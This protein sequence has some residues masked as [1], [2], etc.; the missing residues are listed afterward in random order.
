MEPID[1]FI[2]AS[3]TGTLIEA[4]LTQRIVHGQHDQAMAFASKVQIQQ[5]LPGSIIIEQG[6]ADNTLFFILMGEVSILINGNEIAL[7]QAGTHVGEMAL[8]EP[9]AKRSATV[10][11]RTTTVVAVI[12]ERDFTEI[13]NHY[14]NVWRQIA[15]ELGDRLRQRSRFIRAKNETP[16]MFIGSSRE[17]L[18]VVNTI[19]KGLAAAPFIVRPWTDGVFN[20]SK[21]PIDDL[22]EQLM[23]ADFAV[24]V[25]GPDDKS[26]SRWHFTNSPRDNV[27]LELGLFMGAISRE[28]T[29]VVSPRDK[30]IKIPTDI[31]GMNPIQYISKTG[32]IEDN[33]TPVCEELMALVMKLGSR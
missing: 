1:R 26:L 14:P 9:S 28:R 17:S 22:A 27:V 4:L 2:G 23:L 31:L 11:A 15:S 5:F 16:I 8:I 21:F 12:S 13:A 3:N 18:P 24:L 19:V 6:H 29:Y 33:L 10:L 25:F 7:R 32:I 20:A 30:K